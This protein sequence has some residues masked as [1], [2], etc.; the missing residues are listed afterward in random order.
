MASSTIPCHNSVFTIRDSFGKEVRCSVLDPIDEE[1]V[2]CNYCANASTTPGG[3]L[4]PDILDFEGD[5]SSFDQSFDYDT[6]TP[7]SKSRLLLNLDPEPGERNDPKPDAD[8][9]STA[10]EDSETRKVLTCRYCPGEILQH[11]FGDIWACGL[12]GCTSQRCSYCRLDNFSR[13]WTKTEQTCTF[14]SNRHKDRFNFLSL[15]V[16]YFSP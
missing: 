2:W 6:S 13:H 10:P 15:F 3:G 14:R 8:G 7:L 9:K 1:K 11:V 5:N 16:P 12:E 4:H